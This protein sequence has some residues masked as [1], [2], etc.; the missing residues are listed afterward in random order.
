MKDDRQV[1]SDVYNNSLSAELRSYLQLEMMGPF[2]D[3]ELS[4]FMTD[5]QV[6]KYRSWQ[7]EQSL[8]ED[9]T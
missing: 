7:E 6:T 4:A 8:R 1:H 9:E 5:E 2:T 3:K